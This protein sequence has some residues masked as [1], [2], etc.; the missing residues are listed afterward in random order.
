MARILMVEDNDPVAEVFATALTMAGHDVDH[1]LTPQGAAHR[2]VRNQ[3]DLVLMDLG[4]PGY[5][6]DELAAGMR[7]LGYTGPILV[8]TGGVLPMETAFT[9]RA[10]FAEI[11][12]KPIM[13][14]ELVAAVGRT[15]AM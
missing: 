6:G 7:D 15:L 8:L 12:R 10:R 4:L 2:I 9:D 5:D 1:S 14:D 13:P 3:Y 11:L